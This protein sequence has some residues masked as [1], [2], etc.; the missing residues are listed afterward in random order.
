MNCSYCPTEYGDQYISP[1]TIRAT[2]RKIVQRTT[3][4]SPRVL[5]N[6]TTMKLPCIAFK[7]PALSPYRTRTG[8]LYR[9]DT[10]AFGTVEITTRRDLSRMKTL[11]LVHPWLYALL[12]QEDIYSS[13]FVEDDATPRK[14][15]MIP[16]H[17]LNPN[18]RYTILP[19]VLF[20]WT[21][22]CGHDGMSASP[23]ILLTPV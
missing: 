23:H 18:C 11:Y 10:A 16:C 7:L 15:T 13:A 5:I 12:E 1:L 8:R 3:R 19:S 9:A 6:T 2:I 20:Q 22:R 4:H 21:T 17:S 14:S